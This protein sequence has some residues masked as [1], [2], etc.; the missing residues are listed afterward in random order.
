[1][2]YREYYTPE[3]LND[4]TNMYNMVWYCLYRHI[5]LRGGLHE[6]TPEYEND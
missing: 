5:I 1:M 4:M 6:Y 2:K 3:E